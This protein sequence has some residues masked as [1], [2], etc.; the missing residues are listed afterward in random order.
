MDKFSNNRIIKFINNIA[1]PSPKPCLFKEVIYTIRNFLFY[2]I[3]GSANKSIF[4][5]IVLSSYNSSHKRSIKNPIF[6]FCNSI[7]DE[8]SNFIHYIDYFLDNFLDHSNNCSYYFYHSI[9]KSPSSSPNIIDCPANCS[10]NSSHFY[11]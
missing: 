3:D 8:V 4:H 1:Y 5:N 7:T 6:D 10:N 9:N 11:L 2:P